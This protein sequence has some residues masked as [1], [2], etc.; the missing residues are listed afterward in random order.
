[1]AQQA[2]WWTFPRIDELGSYPDPAGPYYKP[3]SNIQLPSNYPIVALLSGTVTSV[4]N[5]VPWGQTVV[6]IKLDTPLNSEAT[7]TFY[8]HMSS[9]TVTLGQHVNSGDL[10]G[11][12]NNGSPP[13]GFG[14]Y[15]GDVYGSGS[16]W[17]QLQADIAPG[18][19]GLLN[20]VPLLNAAAKAGSDV[21]SLVGATS[22][23]AP[24]SSTG[25]PVDALASQL[26]FIGT[27][28]GIIVIAFV[29]TAFGFYLLFKK[30]IDSTVKK[31]VGVAAKAVI[32]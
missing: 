2:P 25:N 21:S 12:N 18:G 22:N 16:A 13:L 14:L 15:N 23:G 1:M 24:T 29:F 4:Q 11:Y 26:S 27:K 5:N 17:A 19:P 31:G 28:A 9:A 8:E 3:D 10:I 6:T 32:V 30:Q 20:P 7:H